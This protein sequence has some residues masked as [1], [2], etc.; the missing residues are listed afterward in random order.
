MTES[1]SSSLQ[2]L[3]YFSIVVLAVIGATVALSLAKNVLVPL[4]F[5]LFI[6]ALML[7]VMEYLKNRW[8]LNRALALGFASLFYFIVG[9]LGISFSVSSI[10]NFALQWES[11][12][13]RFHTV[14]QE[15]QIF[16]A[17][18]G[19]SVLDM[20]WLEQIGGARILNVGRFLTANLLDWI[21]FWALIGVYLFFLFSGG[22]ESQKF[23]SFLREIQKGLTKYV[24]VKGAVSLS[25]AICVGVILASIGSDLLFLFALLT[26]ILNFIPS[27][28]SILATAL[29][30][31]VIWLQYGF[32]A[33]FFVALGL[34]VGVQVLIGNI[35]EPKLMG[36]SFNLH[37]VTIMFFL[38]FW[39]FV[40]GIA[41][42]FISVP[43]T[44][45][46]QMILSRIEVTKPLADLMSGRFSSEV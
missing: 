14:G 35:I 13:A 36:R 9:F 1:K 21:G 40:W 31:P 11:Y 44:V 4:V 37:P 23:P 10:K 34:M 42:A 24:W 7:P 26:L 5:A 43:L 29:P 2:N 46:T 12:Q 28:G 27:L 38:V 20:D 45:I 16:A 17:K 18:M 6:Y 25:T 3:A 30:L 33:R 39:G 22:S 41:G 32:G 8:K 19:Y 15:L